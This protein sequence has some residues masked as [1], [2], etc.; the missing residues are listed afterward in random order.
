V[1]FLRRRK[2]EHRAAVYDTRPIHGDKEQFE[3][4]QT[5]LTARRPSDPRVHFPSPTGRGD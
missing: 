5:F 1:Q 3:S 2:N 4:R